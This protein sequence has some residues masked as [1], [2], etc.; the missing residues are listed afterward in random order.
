MATI[1]LRPL[2]VRGLSLCNNIV[3]APMAGFSNAAMR[4]LARRWGNP[5]LC[6]TE[7]ISSS[8]LVQNPL[9]QQ[10]YLFL[11]P[12]EGPVAFQLW[13]R[14][15]HILGEAARV[16]AERGAAAIDL[17]CGCPVRKILAA[18]AGVKLMEDPVFLGKIVA[19]MRQS[20][21][22]P[23]SIKIRLGPSLDRSNAV[24]IARIAAEEGVDFITVHGRYGGESYG[25]P[26]RYE[27]IAEVVT[28][29]RMPVF[30]N[31]DV[32]DGRTAAA[33]FAKTGCAGVMIGRAALGAPWV[34]AKIAADLRGEAYEPP[35]PL[36]GEIFL[37][38]Y[39][40]LTEIV[41]KAAILHC[42]KLGCFYSKGRAGGKELRVRLHQCRSREDL[43]VMVARYFR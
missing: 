34:F 27:R 43:L 9:A 1:Y 16:A 22:L 36:I 35:P 3:Q 23:L 26:C 39:D 30:G 6:F 37:H 33:M 11:Y 41:G 13:G 29:A 28:A 12:E 5:G 32:R 2:T 4:L 17:N 8:A 19:R 15:P 24:E 40:L 38:H 7:M 10:R 21:N 25:A 20:I 31:G 18:G 42:R 14:D